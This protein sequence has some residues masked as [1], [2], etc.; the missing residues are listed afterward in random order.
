MGRHAILSAVF[1]TRL[2]LAPLLLPLA[3]PC[4]AEDDWFGG[5]KRAHFVGGVL[6]GGVFSAYTGS[7]GPGIL[8]GCG[9]GAVGELI[10]AVRDGAFTPRASA[11]D[12][13][14]ECVGAVAG[15]LCGREARSGRSGRQGQGD[16]WQRR[17]DGSRQARP[18]PWRT[19]DLGRDFQLHRFGDHGP[20]ER[21]RCRRRGRAGRRG[22]QRLEQPPREREG[23]RRRLPGA[24]SPPA[25]P[26]STS[27]PIASS[28]VGNS[29]ARLREDQRNR[30][31][32]PTQ[33]DH[34]AR[35][36]R[37]RS[38]T[39]PLASSGSDRPPPCARATRSASIRPRPVRPA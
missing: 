35:V 10:E 20:A 22:A 8:L 33:A 13:A 16:P 12:F 11:K 25:S 28:G 9:A 39:K 36:P 3:W 19:R 37:F 4:R 6:I 26:G 5:D 18:I 1:S 21:L 23:L 2:L 31:K 17:V 30:R 24:A 14:A 38:T 34:A 29:R 15:R 27:L 7:H 32:P